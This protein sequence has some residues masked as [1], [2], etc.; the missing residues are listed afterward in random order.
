MKLPE[1]P[2]DEELARA[3]TL[4]EE[5]KA[6]VFRCRGEGSRRRFAV[7][8]CVLRNYGRFLNGYGAVPVCIL[9]HLGQQLGLPPVLFLEPPEREATETEQARRIRQYLGY[10]V[11][12]KNVQERLERRLSTRIDKQ[13]HAG[14]LVQTAEELLRRWKV[15]LPAPSTLRRIPSSVSA[16]A[17]KEVFNWITG[18]LSAEMRRAIGGLLQTPG[19]GGCSEL[20]LLKQYPPEANPQRIA[21]WIERY[22]FLK[23]I[24]AD[25]IDLSRADHGFVRHLAALVRCYDVWEL[26]RFG[27]AKRYAMVA[28]F[29]AESVK[30]ILDRIVAMHDQYTIGMI[31]RSKSN[32]QKQYRGLRKQARKDFN[33]ILSTLEDFLDS[34]C[35]PDTALSDLHLE[36]S[37]PSMRQALANCR[38]FLSLEER[39]YAEHLRRRYSMIR[40]Y[41]PGF[42]DLPFQGET[43]NKLL[44][45][46]IELDRKLNRGEIKEL[47]DGAPDRFVP[48]AYRK[49]LR[50][51]DG[52]LDRHIWEIGLALAVRDALRSGDLYLPESR[53]YVSFWN[54][55][56]NEQAWIKESARAYESLGLPTGAG[57]FIERLEREFHCAARAAQRGMSDNRFASIKAG[58]LQLK[59]KKASEEPDHIKQLRQAINS[60]PPRVRI[61]NLLLEVDSWCGFTDGFK[62]LHGGRGRPERYYET[63]LAALV[64]HGTNLGIATMG[65]SAEE[66]TTHGLQ[67]VS[68][69]FLRE[70]TLKAANAAL[71]NYHHRLGLSSVWGDGTV[72]SSDGQ[73]FGIQASSLLASF[74]PRYFGYY[75]RAVSVYTH[76]SDQHSVFGTKVISCSPREA[77]FVLDGLLENNTILKPREHCT[78]THG[79]TE[80]LFG[81]CYLLG[82]SFMPR[83]KDLKHQQ[84]YKPYREKRYG[85]LENLF[86]SSVDTGLIRKQWDQLVRVAASLRHQTAPA[87][88]IVRRLGGNVRSDQLAKALTALGRIVKTN[89][90][91]RYIQE[92]DVRRRIQLQLNRG[93]GRHNLANHLFFAKQGEFDRGDY[94]E[95]MNKVSCLSL[96]SNAA[97]VWNTV[98]MERIVEQLRAAGHRVPDEDL[99][100]ISPLAF[101]HIL[102]NGTYR[103]HRPKRG[104]GYAYNT[105]P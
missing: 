50:G 67:H 48:T 20:T 94:D 45:R 83:L 102:P 35:F 19:D 71:V 31:R 58:R 53:H 93:E 57:E 89:F 56:Y 80:H 17:Q 92:E 21:L 32:Y 84:L 90:I 36:L 95:I 78:D 37:A 86:R 98:R 55:V 103:F 4:A 30:T 97:L 87:H 72:S 23:S 59:R 22:R 76:V 16:R 24:G 104:D 77:I 33:S 81:L 75:D 63:L 99:A 5:D 34:D 29:L 7:Q 79:Y 100:K 27:P 105:L 44:L 47:P 61:E 40:Q 8:L 101:R 60:H 1:E 28:C 9:N 52:K 10:K 14:D 82:Y 66:I 41:L 69:W 88:V 85:H 26:R 73:R 65:E 49:L 70:D 54:L 42:L 46:A 39:G 51:R 13:S 6:E 38:S 91:L 68:Q 15:V 25:Q 96:L 3:W 11:F 18:A 2:T 12:D 74:Y 62:P 43:G 64:A